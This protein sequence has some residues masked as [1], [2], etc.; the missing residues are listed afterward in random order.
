VRG[1][2]GQ[3]AISH[4]M[5]PKDARNMRKDARA[6]TMRAEVVDGGDAQACR[7]PRACAKMARYERRAPASS[8]QN[9]A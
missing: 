1:A 2:C 3:A 9:V 6:F 4:A 5:M 7:V 8:A